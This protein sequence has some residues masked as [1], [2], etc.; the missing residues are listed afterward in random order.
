MKTNL[1]KSKRVFSFLMEDGATK[2]MTLGYYE[3]AAMNA[4]YV[5]LLFQSISHSIKTIY[6]S[7][8]RPM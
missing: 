7:Q 6:K 3:D 2:Q 4:K 8:K 1:E 5:E